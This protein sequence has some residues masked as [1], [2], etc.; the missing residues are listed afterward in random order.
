MGAMALSAKPIAPM[1]RSY[2][3]GWTWLAVRESPWDQR[4]YGATIPRHS[5]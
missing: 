5:S 2:V 1:G 4:R 3:D